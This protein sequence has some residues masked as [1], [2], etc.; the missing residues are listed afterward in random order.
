MYRIAICDASVADG[1]LS[2]SVVRELADEI[3]VPVSV[4]VFRTTRSLSEAVTEKPYHLYILETVIGGVGGIEF[5]RRLR[6]HG[7]TSEVIFVTK[8]PE[9]ALAA[10]SVF[11]SGYVIKPVAKKKLRD[12]LQHVLEKEG[13]APT[14]LVPTKDG[15]R[16]SVRID[17]ILYVEVF[18]TELVFHCRSG[19]VDGN[20]SLSGLL[21]KLPAK[22]F[23]RSHRSYVV[24]LRYVTKLEQYQFTLLSGDRVT[25]AKNRYAEAKGVLKEFVE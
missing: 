4:D 25:V 21:D 2:E 14:L 15:G 24:N 19:I 16:V 20:G 18:K 6:F 9:Y 17:E 23:Y 8:N 1:K 10:Y 12:A 7:E 13:S 22:Q 3:G 5:A 11:P